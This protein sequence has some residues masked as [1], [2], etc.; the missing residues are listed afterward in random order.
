MLNRDLDDLT[1][2]VAEVKRL[3][4]EGLV[5]KRR[6]T[7][8]VQWIEMVSFV[9]WLLAVTSGLWR[10]VAEASELYV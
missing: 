3:R 4:F 1:I 9:P 7:R 5:G 2:R 6:R 10:L 8:Q